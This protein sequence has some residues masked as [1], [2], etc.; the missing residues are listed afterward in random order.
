M[1]PLRTVP[2]FC[3]LYNAGLHLIKHLRE[4]CVQLCPRW[5]SLQDTCFI[6]YSSTDIYLENIFHVQ[7]VTFSFS[8][9][10][11]NVANNMTLIKW[12]PV[13]GFRPF[14]FMICETATAV[15]GESS[16]GESD[17]HLM[18]IKTHHSY[19]KSATV[20][21]YY[22]IKACYLIISW[23]GDLQLKAGMLEVELRV[24]GDERNNCMYFIMF[25]INKRHH[26]YI[27]HRQEHVCIKT[28]DR[29]LLSC[30][31]RIKVF[32]S[33]NLHVMMVKVHHSYA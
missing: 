21:I 14:H 10:P 22:I 12:D 6:Y 3:Y 1:R 5:A 7:Q 17:L 9:S 19:S 2:P 33:I 4:G 23:L 26:T 16:L 28:V 27:K 32:V 15:N 8:I 25:H 11:F 29:E 18:L 13:V 30:K 24:V 20:M 31:W